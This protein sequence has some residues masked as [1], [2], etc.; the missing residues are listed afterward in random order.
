M[1]KPEENE[2]IKTVIYLRTLKKQGK[3][4]EFFAPMNE[5]K[6]SRLNK[7]LAIKIEQKARKMGKLKGASDLVVIFKKCVL[8]LEMKQKKRKLKNGA[9]SDS[10]C[11]PTD[12][13]TNFLELVNRSNVSI[14]AV[15]Y[16]F[17]EAKYIIDEIIKEI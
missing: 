5:N 9:L 3:I 6:A 17:D 14:G 15:A 11:K 2:Q 10:H 4:I 12:E 1:K 7:M 8:F 13:Q 16:G